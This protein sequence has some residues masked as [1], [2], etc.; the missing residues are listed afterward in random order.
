MFEYWEVDGVA[1]S[2]SAIS[3]VM[4]GPHTA[5]AKYV[6]K[7]RLIVDSDNN[8]GNPQGSN[9][10]N[11]GYVANFS[12]STPVGILVQQVFVQWTGDY[13]GSTPIGSILMD[14]PHEV[15]AVWTT[16]YTQ[17]ISIIGIITI[18]VTTLLILRGRHRSRIG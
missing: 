12:V 16:S 13:A 17:L 2:A 5:V 11:A 3:F 15:Q 18:T 7:Y 8:L 9:Y 10:Y 4:N 6:T 1:E 14:R